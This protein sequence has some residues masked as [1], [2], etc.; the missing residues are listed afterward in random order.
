MAGTFETAN[1]A[2]A[3]EYEYE[4]TTLRKSSLNLLR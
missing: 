4:S 3:A 1:V 2:D